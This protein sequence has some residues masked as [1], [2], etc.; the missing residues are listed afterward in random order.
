MAVCGII[1]RYL[2]NIPQP[3]AI[4]PLF[5]L[6]TGYPQGKSMPYPQKT[7]AHAPYFLARLTFPCDPS[8]T[9]LD[10]KT[11]GGRNGFRAAAGGKGGCKSGSE[12]LGRTDERWVMRS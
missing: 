10:R 12:L 2:Q 8:F 3:A 5:A 1:S 9:A 6:S 7:F 11:P 4:A